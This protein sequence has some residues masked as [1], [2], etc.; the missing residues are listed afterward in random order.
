[1]NS[2]TIGSAG[3]TR[4]GAGTAVRL[5]RPAGRRKPPSLAGSPLFE[6]APEALLRAV[7]ARFRPVRWDRGEPQPPELDRPDHLFVVLEGLV[8]LIALGIQG[9]P[10]AAALIG[11]GMLYSTL[12]CE[13]PSDACALQ[14]SE[15]VAIPAAAV[16]R[17]MALQPAIG[18]NLA[19]A[20]SQRAASLRDA[21]AQVS[22]MRVE[23]RLLGHLHEL[24]DHFGRASVRGIELRLDLTHAQWGLLAG[25]SRVATTSALILLRKRGRIVADGRTIVVPWQVVRSDLWEQTGPTGAT[26]A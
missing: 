7:E 15:I 6:G 23:D 21:V 3:P 9:R 11:P 16:R 24:C 18:A 5:A 22:Q 26:A 14:T 19:V 10:V 8:G 13:R 17:L 2:T 4:I 12:G 1:L 25:A 20:L